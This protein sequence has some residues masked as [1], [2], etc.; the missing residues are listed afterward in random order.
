MRTST[1]RSSLLHCSVRATRPP[2][3]VRRTWTGRSAACALSAHAADVIRSAPTSISRAL[4]PVNSS[5]TS[6]F[7]VCQSLVNSFTVPPR[8]RSPL[9]RLS[10]RLRH[11]RSNTSTKIQVLASGSLHWSFSRKR[12]QKGV[13]SKLRG[14]TGVGQARCLVTEPREHL[15]HCTG[16]SGQLTLSTDRLGTQASVLTLYQTTLE[17]Q[18]VLTRSRVTQSSCRALI[19]ASKWGLLDTAA[20]PWC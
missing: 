3:V 20:A 4:T 13:R 12:S 6:A 18:T 15:Q 7:T 16:I 14:E 8:A 19:R 1:A 11:S 5:R 10:V 2:V 17:S 9:R